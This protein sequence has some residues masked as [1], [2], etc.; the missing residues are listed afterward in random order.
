MFLL[1]F[2][3]ITTFTNTPNSPKAVSVNDMNFR[4]MTSIIIIITYFIKLH[5]H[6]DYTNKIWPTPKTIISSLILKAYGFEK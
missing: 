1:D 5:F 6:T 4:N 2:H 3:S